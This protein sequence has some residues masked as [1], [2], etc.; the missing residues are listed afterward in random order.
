MFYVEFPSVDNWE[1]EKRRRYEEFVNKTGIRPGIILRVIEGRV[2]KDFSY[3]RYA[4]LFKQV[5]TYKGLLHEIPTRA[6]RT[7][8][9][10]LCLENGLLFKSCVEADLIFDPV[11]LSE[12]EGK[13]YLL[14]CSWEGNIFQV[15]APDDSMLLNMIIERRG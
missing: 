3:L 4:D 2:K 14:L 5:P 15:I 1:N 11:E 12:K 10:D 6:G 7:V 13:G 8:K 9:L